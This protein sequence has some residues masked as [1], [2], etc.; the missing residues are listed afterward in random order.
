MSQLVKRSAATLAARPLDPQ[1]VRL[2]P[3]PLWSQALVWAIIGTATAAFGFAVMAKIDEVVVAPGTL[4][5]QGAERPIKSPLAG[6]VTTLYVKEGE[7]VVQGQPLLRLDP[8]VSA[9]RSSTLVEQTRLERQQASE[10]TRAFA[11]RADS[12]RAKQ[13]ALR[14]AMVIEQQ[15]LKQIEP[16]AAVGAMQQVQVLQ[17]RNWVQQL[18]SDIAQAEANLREVQ[19][20]LVRQRQESLRNLADLDR[21]RVE[22]KEVQDQELLRAPLDGVV[23]DLVPSSSGYA[24][25]ANETLLKLVPGGKLEA[26]VFFSNREVGFVK[27]GQQAQVRVDAFPFT[28][29][30]SI[31]ATIKAVSG[32]ALPADQHN[33]EP[34]FPGYV[35]LQR[36][37]LARDGRRYAIGPG[38][39]VQVN[40][41]LRQKRVITLLTDV[42]DRAFDALRRIRST[43]APCVDS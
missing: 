41:V 18:R 37:F 26:K 33:P 2:R 27:A 24:A 6:V 20:E 30:G 16:L 40:V 5:P 29:F 13:E 19:A 39:S 9:K 22:V 21:Q 15:I 8:D 11:A 17:Q 31:P 3:A 28:Q 25:S 12:L 35:Q 14:Q 32:Y 7:R 43:S 38:Q 1:E 34:R 42:L 4:Q 23:F 10:Q 36:D